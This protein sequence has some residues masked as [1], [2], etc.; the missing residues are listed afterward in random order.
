[1]LGWVPA[2]TGWRNIL[3]KK[4]ACLL[5]ICA[6]PQ[7]QTF[8]ELPKKSAHPLSELSDFMVIKYC[9]L[10]WDIGT[11]PGQVQQLPKVIVE[12]LPLGGRE[13]QGLSPGLTPPPPHPGAG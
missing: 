12:V 11:A 9:L 4:L 2:R 8:L 13:E 5:H 3:S 7:T 10:D 6:I 1:M